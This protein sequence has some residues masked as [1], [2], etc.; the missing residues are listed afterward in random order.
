MI[1]SSQISGMV[2]AGGQGSRMGGLDKG[3]QAFDGKPLALNALRRLLPQVGS[4][5]MNA[6]RNLE[7]YASFGVPVWPDSPGTANTEDFA[8]PL[9]GFLTGLS[10][11]DTPYLL[12]VPCDVPF[13]PGDLAA[14]LAF[15]FEKKQADVV[16]AALQ[17]SDGRVRPQPVFCLMRSNLRESLASFLRSGGR[18][19][20]L[21]TAQ[22]NTQL[23]TFDGPD[24]ARA[25]SNVNTLEELAWLQ[26]SR[27]ATHE[28][29][30]TPVPPA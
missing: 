13:F 6:N 26:A 8:G 17:G 19:P 20:G 16:M 15:T 4:V 18:K 27:R 3:L 30:P 28:P 22:H 23:V 1:D 29:L 21:W 11:C 5:Y 7:V 10:H 12:T 14:R 9:A 25:F 2:L 24:D